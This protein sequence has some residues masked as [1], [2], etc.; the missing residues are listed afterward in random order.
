MKK[1]A[2]L[3][4]L[5]MLLVAPA[6]ST[7]VKIHPDHVFK[8]HIQNMVWAKNPFFMILQRYFQKTTQQTVWTI[9]NRNSDFTNPQDTFNDTSTNDTT[10]VNTLTAEELR[11]LMSSDD[12]IVIVDVR[13]NDAYNSGHIPCSFSIPFYGCGSCFVAHMKPFEG[14]KIVSYSTDGTVGEAACRLL[15]ENGFEEVYNLDGGIDSWCSCGFTVTTSQGNNN[16]GD[17]GR[18]P[19]GHLPLDSSVKPDGTR[20]VSTADVPPRWDWRKAEYNGVKGNW[21]TSVKNQG[22]CGSCWAFAADGALEA[23]INIKN[24]NPDLDMDLSEQYLLSCGGWGCSPSNAYYAYKFMYEVGGTVPESCF[25]YQARGD[26]PCD[27]ICP[28]WESKIIPITGF[29]YW[30]NPGRKFIQSKLIELGPLCVSMKV[31]TDFQF[32]DGGV[33]RHRYGKLE[34]SHQ[35]VLVGYNNDKGYWICKNSW[36]KKWGE[37]GWFKIAYGECGI[38]EE[39][40]YVKYEKHNFP[41]ETPEKPSGP[42]TGAAEVEYAYST[43]A[44]D[45]DNDK[46]YYLFDWGDDTDSGWLGPFKSG[47]EVSATHIWN[48]EG[49]YNVKVKVRDYYGEES[50]WS[51]SLTVTI[52]ATAPKVEVLSPEDGYL[53]LNGRAIFPL[54]GGKWNNIVIGDM[55]IEVSAFDECTGV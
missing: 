49:Y 41:P 14:N 45:P 30:M 34:G 55:D 33:Y 50:K 10:E 52:D 9:D 19:L 39:V 35:I 12:S 20:T 26:I 22:H 40:V 53:Y 31:Y 7:A 43:V 23:I 6:L 27:S 3:G 11:A 46:I 28:D 47:V 54:S 38:E 37:N 24:N 5:L 17:T 13:D 32:Y 21:M 29:G 36:G 8:R 4:I 16:N 51:D 48:K 42:T 18:H 25:P 1:L 44:V 15:L 2:V